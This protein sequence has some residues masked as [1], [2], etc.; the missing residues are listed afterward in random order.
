[1]INVSFHA[2]LD[3]RFGCLSFCSVMCCALV[4]VMECVCQRHELCSDAYA[5]D[6]K[7]HDRLVQEITLN[8]L[9]CHMN[10]GARD[11]GLVTKVYSHINSEKN[12]HHS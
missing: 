4:P 3:M 1:M 10:P 6:T 9:C 8:T 2:C 12:M 7:Y 5:H 11:L